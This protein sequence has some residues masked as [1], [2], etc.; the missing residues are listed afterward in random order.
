MAS[1]AG[2]EQYLV[3]AFT[4]L[5][6]QLETIDQPVQVDVGWPGKNLQR[7][8]VYIGRTTGS[9]TFNFIQDGPKTRDDDFTMTWVFRA[10][11][12][13]ESLNDVQ[14]RVESYAEAF[15]LMIARDAGLDG[16]GDETVIAAFFEDDAFEGPTAGWTEEGADAF[17]TCDLRV[18]IRTEA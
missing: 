1:R 15:A 4:P 7:N 8:H 11:G 6:A 13:N 10:S 12:S 18:Q 9:W 14:A 5:L 2:V 16:M 17:I 3:D